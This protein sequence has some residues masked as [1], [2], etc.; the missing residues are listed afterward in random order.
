V[1]QSGRHRLDE[2][3]ST[4]AKRAGV[5]TI[6]GQLIKGLV[7]FVGLIAFSHLLSPRDIGLIAMISVFLMLGETLRDF[8]LL[9]AAI[10][11]PVLTH[12][13]ASNLFW[14]NALIGVVMSSSLIVGAPAI[15]LMYSEPTLRVLA[16]WIALSFTINALQTQFQVRLARDLRFVALTV[17]DAASQLVGLTAGLIAAVAGAGYWSLV[18]QM[19]SIY[20]SLLLMR[21]VVAGWWP[22]LPRREAGMKA[23]YIFGLNSGLSQLVNFIAYNTDSYLIGTR[24]GASALGVYNRAFQMFTVPSNQLLGPLTNVALP[25]LSR[26][27]HEGGDFYP[28]LLKAQITISV[29]LTAMFSLA[30]ALAHQIVSIA[31]GP[32]WNESATLLSILSIG[33][34]VQVMSY[35]GFWAFLAS[36]NARH[37]FLAG[38]V[39]RSLL[40][41]CIVVG[42][43]GGIEGVAWGFTA[44]LAMAW[45]INL[46]WLKRCD[47]MPVM[48]FL[49]SGIHVLLCGLVA[50][51]TGWIFASGF[52]SSASPGVLLFAGSL[53]VAA[54]YSALLMANRTTRT[55]LREV[56]A[57]AIAR[58]RRRTAS[59]I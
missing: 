23:L 7:Q 53:L 40:V 31:L 37:L 4:S 56:I 20:V 45:F 41:L 6:I 36:G 59:R 55:V 11:T 46:A 18:I 48:A 12:G 51:V 3:R 15:A 50:G 32:V 2:P 49:R 39:T 22:G 19:L 14:S 38:L 43:L 52:N 24:W 1:P 35:I 13:Q 21:A 8:G 47:S 30:A 5:I 34:A 42:S 57:P 9:Q 26:R 28:L 44:G 58:L 16:P 10:Q 33:G 29:A 25:L 54:I 17:T 27:R